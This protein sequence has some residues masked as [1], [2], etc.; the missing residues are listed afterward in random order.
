[1]A[2][3]T[4]S[5]PSCPHR[6]P[7]RFTPS[8]ASP[9]EL[10]GGWAGPRNFKPPEGCE[11]KRGEE[12]GEKAKVKGSPGAPVRRRRQGRKSPGKN[13]SVQEATA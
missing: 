1:M 4:G 2:E 8:L 10:E 6:L 9:V 12:G 11:Q 5:A 7:A 3:L 13:S